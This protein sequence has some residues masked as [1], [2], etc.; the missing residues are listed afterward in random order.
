MCSKHHFN[1]Q[2]KWCAY[3]RLFFC[4]L[5]FWNDNNNN[6][7]VEMHVIC[8]MLK[9]E[10]MYTMKWMCAYHLSTQNILNISLWAKATTTSNDTVF[11]R[12][13]KRTVYSIDRRPRVRIQFYNNFFLCSFYSFRLFKNFSTWNCSKTD[14]HTAHST[15]NVLVILFRFSLLLFLSHFDVP[16]NFQTHYDYYS[17][18]WKLNCVIINK[19]SASK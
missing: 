17:S 12:I 15:I 6:Q 8:W 2:L 5:T 7:N 13:H 18:H 10:R 4:L 9:A 19:C 16:S 14:A 3:S 1:A 11:F